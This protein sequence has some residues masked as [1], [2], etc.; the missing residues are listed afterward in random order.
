MEEIETVLKQINSDFLCQKQLRLHNTLSR[1]CAQEQLLATS[2][3]Y[4]KIDTLMSNKAN[5]NV[6]IGN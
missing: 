6:N 4:I 3:K 1:L 2:S 5:L